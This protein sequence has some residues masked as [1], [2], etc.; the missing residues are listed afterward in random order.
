MKIMFMGTP[1]IS[2]LSLRYLVESGFDVCAVVTG[3]DKPRGRGNE[4]RPTPTKAL[5]L[6]YGIEVLTPSTLRT[7]EFMGELAR[8]SPDIIV[9]VAFGKILPKA[10]LDFPPLGCINLHVSLL[11]KYRGAAPMQ[12]AIM[13][14]ERITGVTIMYM[15]EG[16]DTG[17]I[18]S[19]ESFPIG[20]HDDFE[21]IHDRSAEVGSALLAAAL[22]DIEAGRATRTPQDESLACYAAKVEK[23]DG[24]IDFSLPAK[25]L[26]CI[27]RGTTPI[28]GAY[29]YKDG[30]L[31][32][33]FNAEPISAK[34]RAGEVIEL[35]SHG[36][37]YF[38][39]ACGEGALRVRGVIPEGKG[40]MTAG[41]FI[42]GRKI[43]L[44][45]ILE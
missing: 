37:G 42:R 40:R 9:V 11:P 44:G 21:A 13:E 1:E 6:E 27:I 29:V 2:A 20:E 4:M 3:Q 14:G 34:G 12:R 43:Q 10:V 5:A 32:K 33:I 31:L 36:E 38:T 45:D 30:R 16:L 8:I 39:V 22:R 18:I 35:D 7:E 25:K 15:A 41:D 28:P 26:D 23:T 24:K 19:Q 17:D